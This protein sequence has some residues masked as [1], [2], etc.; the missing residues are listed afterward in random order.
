MMQMRKMRG[1][2]A[3][4]S[5]PRGRLAVSALLATGL[6]CGSLVID[7]AHADPALALLWKHQVGGT[8][9]DYATAVATDAVGNVIVAGPTNGPFAGPNKGGVDI[10]I[11]AFAASGTPLWK[12]KLAS[13]ES[14]GEAH[15][16]IDSDG[17]LAVASDTEGS[18]GQSN[19]GRYDAFVVSYASDGTVRWRHQPGT[20]RLDVVTAVAASDAG[21]VVIAGWT[22]GRL[23]E[24]KK[25]GTDGF[26]IKY[27]ANGAEQWRHQLGTTG[28]DEIAGV[29]IDAAGNVVVAGNTDGS[30]VGTGEGNTDGFIV[31][32]A[33]NGTE[34]WRTQFGSG[35]TD[36]LRRV[37]IDESRNIIV[38][39]DTSGDLGGPSNG[40]WDV[41]VSA[42]APDGTHRWSAQLGAASSDSLF[43]LA[44][45]TAGDIVLAYKIHDDSVGEDHPFCSVY[46]PA[47]VLKGTQPL[48]VSSDDPGEFTLDNADNV[49]V[50]GFASG[51]PDGDGFVAKYAPLSP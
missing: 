51:T 42:Y 7:A 28:D 46:S 16:A 39:G 22:E 33:P 32:Y 23:A 31:K 6:V 17:N 21:H 14:E 43:G 13:G 10:F 9:F 20:R 35:L 27:A 36:R 37:A 4:G 38:A 12:R 48:P 47:G 30:L 25:G 40:E 1:G 18:I 26:V 24:T 44:I 11:A 45:D 50:A 34:L 29:A 3:T 2:I 49:I 15:L 41:F 8:G 5:V 19:R